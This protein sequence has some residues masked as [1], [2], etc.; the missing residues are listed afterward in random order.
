MEVVL[1]RHSKSEQDMDKQQLA[2]GKA[3][4]RSFA[5]HVQDAYY[6]HDENWVV[7]DVNRRACDMLGY[8][9]DELIGM[10]PKDYDAFILD[11]SEETIR[12]KLAMGN[13]VR[14]DTYHRRKDGSTFPVE[15]RIF[16]HLEGERRLNYALVSDISDRMH[17]E[18]AMMRMN[19]ELRAVTKCHHILLRAQDEK[20][21]LDDVCRIIC[22]D[23]GYRMAWVGLIEHDERKSVRPVASAGYDA[24]YVANSNISWS[25]S[26]DRGQGPVG[27]VVRSGAVVRIQDTANDPRIALWRDSA[28]ERGYRSSLGI[29]LKKA[30]TG[31]VFGVLSIYAS[32]PDAFVPDEVRLL[33]E[34]ADDMAFGIEVLRMRAEH[35][36][37]ELSLRRGE[38]RYRTIFMNS[39]LG[40]FRSTVEG[41]F[42]EINPALAEMLGYAS[43]EDML[44][45]ITN[46]GR[47][48]YADPEA[49]KE[50]VARQLQAP[51][52][53]MQ[54]TNRY[55]RRDNSER[56]AN[57]YLKTIRDSEGNPMFFDGIV[58][59]ITD[60]LH[61]EKEQQQLEAQLAQA[62]KMES[63]G[64]LAG[65]VAHDFNNM[66]GAIMGYS[67]LA[68]MQ[69][70]PQQRMHGYIQEIRK[71]AE[72]SANLTRQLLAFARKQ[73]IV[74]KVLDLNAI[75]QGMLSMLRRLID[76][77]IH[78]EWQPEEG[79]WPVKMDPGQIDQILANLCV[80]ARDAI[81]GVGR[82]TIRTENVSLGEADC[83]DRAGFVPGE[84]VCLSVADSGCGMSEEVL[85]NIFEPFYTT[86]EQGKGTGLGLSMVYGIVK[87]NGGFIDVESAPGNGTTFRIFLPRHVGAAVKAENDVSGERVLQGH[88]TILLVEDDQALL[89]IVQLMLRE[90]GYH[91]LPASSPS[92]AILLATDQAKTGK[93]DLLITDMVMPEMNGREL[94]QKLLDMLPGMHCLFMSGYADNKV[95]SGKEQESEIDFIQKPFT[96]ADL[97][98]RVRTS[99]NR[100]DVVSASRSD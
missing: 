74:T 90:S 4:L 97:L 36:Q 88:E 12:A 53:I 35:D 86:K 39:P 43:P 16:P 94:A 79:L 25:R 45:E 64:R 87:Q 15:V 46:I 2:V 47:Q 77:Q 52:S 3:R 50:V 49:R 18:N 65:G 84:F 61:S 72:R 60:K 56:M 55:L 14:F 31:E 5:D 27:R 40:L 75:V 68:L 67:D 83:T 66:L 95:L 24:G 42:I 26:T 38:E 63:V 30:K 13:E 10:A 29:P 57:L 41:E 92:E 34:L 59:D 71:A 82:I 19:R 23:A 1:E 98:A 58:E 7:L 9:R 76:E 69:L 93:I 48:I 96:M 54:Y 89:N 11:H 91:V 37:A 100:K 70:D 99:L 73:N 17:M 28:L 8:S 81:D 78:L 6:L 21:L 80:N 44:H 22:E 32:E 85:R 62:Q 20:A 33:S 51:G